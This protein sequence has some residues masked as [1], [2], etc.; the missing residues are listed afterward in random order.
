MA[1]K[2]KAKTYTTAK[3]KTAFSHII[4]PDFGTKE[5]PNPDGS[6]NITLRMSEDEIEAFREMIA[7]EITAAE[8]L[9][10]EG[11]NKLKPASRKKLG[12]MSFNLIGVEEYD[13]ETEEPTGYHLVRFKTSATYKNKQGTLTQRKVPLFNSKGQPV[14]I[15]DDLGYGSVVKV[16]F[17]ASPYFVDGQGMG[18]L[19][20]YLN[21]VQI[22]C[23]ESF[24]GRNAEA[25]GFGAE[26]DGDF[27]GDEADGGVNESTTEN[28]TSVEADDVPF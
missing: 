18:G 10:E 23:K 14:K 12:Q 28:T 27:Y 11:F 16:A 20:L 2:K 5:Y 4:E 3:S 22:L 13:R 24:G 6:F 8:A 17:T 1:E 25:Y 19:S 9:A 21:A 26:E 7:D 15:T